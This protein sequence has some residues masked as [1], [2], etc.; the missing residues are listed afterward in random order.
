[1]QPV[2]TRLPVT[3]WSSY[4]DLSRDMSRDALLVVDCIGERGR[5][6]AVRPKIY[7]KHT[8]DKLINSHLFPRIISYSYLTSFLSD[9]A[10]DRDAFRHPILSQ[11][12]PSAEHASRD[13]RPNKENMLETDESLK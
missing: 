4:M 9:V 13:D 11:L 10:S 5:A 8:N 6:S 1:M 7:T 3:A 12:L 2:W